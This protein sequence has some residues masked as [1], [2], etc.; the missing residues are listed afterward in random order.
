MRFLGNRLHSSRKESFSDLVLVL[1]RLSTLCGK[2]CVCERE[3]KRVRGSRVDV[4]M[5]VYA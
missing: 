4:R 5:C 3:R 1:S 2:R